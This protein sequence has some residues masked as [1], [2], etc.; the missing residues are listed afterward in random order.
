MTPVASWK[1]GMAFWM[2]ARTRRE[3]WLATHHHD[4]NQGPHGGVTLDIGRGF[5][6]ISVF[7]TNVPPRFRLHH[8]D[9]N[10]RPLA[11][12][13]NASVSIETVRPDGQRQTFAFA[14]EEDFLKSTT[15][16]PEPHEFRVVLKLAQG[17]HTRTFETEFVENHHHH[18]HDAAGG[19]FEDAHQREHAEEF[20][21]RFANRQVTTGQLILFGLTGGLLPCPSAFAVLMICLQPKQNPK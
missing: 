8:F 18:S 5:V 12:P 1:Y 9:K 19:E 10:K 17:G 16:L 3:Q 14:S 7:E 2:L 13:K 20:K 21:N 15:D 6:E 4:H 11:P